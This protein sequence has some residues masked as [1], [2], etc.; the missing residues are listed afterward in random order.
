M[1]EEAAMP[2]EL[3]RDPQSGRALAVRRGAKE[4]KIVRGPDGRATGVQ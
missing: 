2:A 4:R 1:Q 3:V